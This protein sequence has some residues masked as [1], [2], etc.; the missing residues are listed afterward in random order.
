MLPF[1]SSSQ[2][3][4][5][6]DKLDEDMRWKVLVKLKHLAV[7]FCGFWW[8]RSECCPQCR[9]DFQKLN[10]ILRSYHQLSIVEFA[11]RNFKLIVCK[12]SQR[13]WM[14]FSYW[15]QKLAGTITVVSFFFSFC[16]G[17]LFFFRVSKLFLHSRLNPYAENSMEITLS[18]FLPP[19]SRCFS[20]WVTTVAKKRTISQSKRRVVEVFLGNFCIHSITSR[21]FRNHT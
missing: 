11:S 21:L 16:S 9:A 7:T 5:E 8:G 15:Y 3:K 1:A 12:D 4:D 14:K 19:N 18:E 6:N 10:K 13:T 17:S 20:A 2:T